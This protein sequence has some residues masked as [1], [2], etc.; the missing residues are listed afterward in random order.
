MN[1]IYFSLS[2]QKSEEIKNSLL[3]DAIDS[4]KIKADIAAGAAGLKVI[5]VKSIIVGEAGSLPPVPV[6]SAKALD[7][8][9]ASATPII[10][11]QQEISASVSIVYLIG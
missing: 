4:A 2:N 5:G 11:G 7:G 10:S 3:K 9:A 1:N 8:E 6:Y